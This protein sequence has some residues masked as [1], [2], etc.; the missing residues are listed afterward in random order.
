MA[1][2]KITAEDGLT[3]ASFAPHLG[4]LMLSLTLP[5]PEAP[6]KKREILYL[7][8]DFDWEK[9]SKIRGG[10][11]FCFPICGR[12]MREG[13]EGVYLF[14][15]RRYRMGI[16][17]FAHEFP[18]EV[19]Y[20]EERQMGMRLSYNEKTMEQYPFEFEV[21]LH[22]EIKE[23][24]ILCQHRYLNVSEDQV[25]PYYAGFH[26]YFWIDPARY[27]KDQ[28]FL[29][30]EVSSEFFYNST[31]SDIVDSNEKKMTLSMPL[32]SPD[33]NERLFYFDREAG[34]E[35]HFPDRTIIG[36]DV[37]NI[38]G[39]E[40]STLPFMQ[41]YHDPAKPF[42]C[43]EP[44]MS[45]PNAMNTQFATHVLFPGEVEEASFRISMKSW[46]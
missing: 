6:D 32:S 18:W 1:I 28:V 27:R 5:D 16:H 3:T 8:E 24:E 17:G 41:L 30:A 12:L 33:L 31:L 21:E 29:C 23:G 45:H 34:F 40:G 13:E 43:V 44:W 26:P 36:F 46:K 9:P 19:L 15:G 20:A 22:F 4:G 11:P 2:I 38:E 25:M 14:D 39:E 7:P 42:F 37:D 35:L 10:F